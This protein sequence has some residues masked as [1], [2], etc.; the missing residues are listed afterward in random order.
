MYQLLI[1]LD[2]S[3]H[4]DSSDINFINIGSMVP[5]IWIFKDLI[6]VENFWAKLKT[7]ESSTL[8]AQHTWHLL[9]TKSKFI[10]YCSLQHSYQPWF[11]TRPEMNNLWIVYVAKMSK[12]LN[13]SH[14]RTYMVLTLFEEIS[15]RFQNTVSQLLLKL[16]KWFWCH[17]NQK[18][19]ICCLKKWSGSVC[20]KYKFCNQ[21]CFT[22][23]Y[24]YA[25]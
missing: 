10:L 20:K 23:K 18:N 8:Q 6:F 17:W 2:R 16:Q 25:F 22:T 9:W 15:Q 19:K 13:F 12:M 3:F 7:H 11:F 21:K 14:L 4:S 24:N 5:E 1:A